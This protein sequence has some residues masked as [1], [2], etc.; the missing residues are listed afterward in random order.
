MSQENVDFVLRF[1]QPEPDVDFG[2]LFRDDATWAAFVET[3]GSLYHPDFKFLAHGLPDGD[4]AYVGLDDLRTAWL[5]WLSPWATYRAEVVEAVDLGERVLLLYHSYGRLEGSTVEV[6][7][8]LAS[9][10][11]VRDAEITYVE[12]YATTHT[13]AFKAVGLE[14]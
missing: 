3:S 8:E 5:D 1:I 14:E 10:W 13:E 2:Q 9:V 6:K 11:T 12:F 4:R 7:D